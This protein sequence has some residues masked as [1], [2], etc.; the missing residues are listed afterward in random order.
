VRRAALSSSVQQEVEFIYRESVQLAELREVI[1]ENAKQQQRAKAQPVFGGY[2]WSL[3][4][5]VVDQESF[6]PISHTDEVKDGSNEMVLGSSYVSTEHIVMFR[7]MINNLSFDAK[8]VVNLI[9]EMPDHVF[10][11]VVTRKT[12]S[13]TAGSIV[14][15]LHK[16]EGWTLGRISRVIGEIQA[17]LREL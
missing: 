16:V 17:G 4:L 2:V 6:I 13:L 7:E 5:G 15:Y 12:K 11:D 10:Q 8:Q 9:L 3:L 14:R 1:V